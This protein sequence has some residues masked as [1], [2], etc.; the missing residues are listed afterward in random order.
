MISVDIVYS[1][2]PFIVNGGFY[3]SKSTIGTILDISKPY[4]I[5]FLEA[6][7]K[8][9]SQYL[10]SV[11]NSLSKRWQVHYIGPETH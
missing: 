8:K 1:N 9:S 11:I 3:Y 10:I 6:L 7:L 4:M 5:I 2:P